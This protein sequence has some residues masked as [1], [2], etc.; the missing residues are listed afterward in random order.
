MV[1]NAIY[2]DGKRAIQPASLDQTYDELRRCPDTGHSFCW[3]GLPRP[4]AAEIQSVAEEFN[5]HPLAVED[6]IDAHQRPKLERYGET[7]SN[8][9]TRGQRTAG[10]PG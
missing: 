4:S 6:A 5:L 1:N 2:T 3:I 7:L 9:S 8:I 10:R